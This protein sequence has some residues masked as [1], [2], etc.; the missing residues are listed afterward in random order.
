MQFYHPKLSLL[1][2]VSEIKFKCGNNEG[3][4]QAEIFLE[5]ILFWVQLCKNG[6]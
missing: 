1:L 3:Y 6:I 4:G 2:V 5:I